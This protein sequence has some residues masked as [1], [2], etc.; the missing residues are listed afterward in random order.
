MCD[1]V[2]V[3]SAVERETDHMIRV[4]IKP[5]ERIMLNHS[6]DTYFKYKPTKRGASTNDVPP[7][8]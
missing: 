5:N 3:K 6:A 4:K 8:S 1:C 2:S 7:L